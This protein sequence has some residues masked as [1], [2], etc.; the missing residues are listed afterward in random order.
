MTI[1]ELSAFK[2]GTRCRVFRTAQ[3]KRFD[4]Q[5]IGIKTVH[6]REGATLFFTDGTRTDAAACQTI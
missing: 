1:A 5:P 2:P 3:D 4:L 6:A